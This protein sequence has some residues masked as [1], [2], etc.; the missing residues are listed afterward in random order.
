MEVRQQAGEHL[1]CCMLGWRPVTFE[2][3]V[4]LNGERGNDLWVV[5]VKDLK[6]L[7]L[8]VTD[9]TAL[10]VAYDN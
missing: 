1:A 3:R 9:S 6:V 2:R 5:V 8:E 10:L 7:L 4:L